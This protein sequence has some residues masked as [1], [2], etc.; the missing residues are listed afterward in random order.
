MEKK[1]VTLGFELNA[2]PNRNGLHTVF[3]RIMYDGKLKRVKV[4]PPLEVK[5]SNWNQKGTRGAYFRQSDINAE[6]CNKILEDTLNTYRAII[7][8]L[9]DRGTLTLENI[10]NFQRDSITS[11]S[12]LD[13]VSERKQYF[14]NI[15]KIRNWKRY[16]SFERKLHTFVHDELGKSD[17]LYNELNVAFLT[18]Y[19]SWLSSQRN[20]YDNS[21]V[22]HPNTVASHLRLLR[23]IVNYAVKEDK[24]GIENNPFLRFTF[25]Q[26]QT[27]KEALTAEQIESVKAL[28][29]K[30]GSA[31][32]KVRNLFLFSYYNAGIRI[33]DLLQLRWR[34]I[35]GR[36]LT[37]TMGKNHK[38]RQITCMTDEA[39]KIL[40][41]YKNEDV[42][43]NDYIFVKYKANSPWIKYVTDD[44]R[45]SMPPSVKAKL[46]LAISGRTE[47]INM[48]LKKLAEMAGIETNLSTHIARHSFARAAKKAGLDNLEVKSL[49]GHSN[50]A[51]TEKYM[52]DFGDRRMDESFAKVF[53]GAE[54]KDILLQQLKELP[55]SELTA[56][57]AKL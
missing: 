46:V 30:K 48:N 50:L 6:T 36:A 56:L 11:Q 24:I 5:K 29:L 9:M 40:E 7:S 37:Y 53:G 16:V 8:E 42:Q 31:L 54:K 21:K 51:T 55:T 23:T 35:E 26:V 2:K 15:G 14:Y 38:K 43:P 20:E 27:K 12:F 34:N 44:E 57:L 47:T 49:L 33:G 4:I 10:V 22:L 41:L 52:G 28:D 3:L 13:Y 17:L 1:N 19:K 25:S 45:D 32:W 39:M 18:K